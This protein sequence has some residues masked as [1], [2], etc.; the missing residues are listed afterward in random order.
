MSLADTVP[1]RFTAKSIKARNWMNK[2]IDNPLKMQVEGDHYKSKSIQ[3]IEYIA[4]NNLDFMEGSIVKYI[5]RHKDKGGAGD[6]RKAIHYCQFILK[7]HYG[8]S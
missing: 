6:V 2:S 5:T 1:R 8:E 7:Y 3:P 4:S